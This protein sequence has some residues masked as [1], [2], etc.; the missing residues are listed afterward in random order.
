MEPTGW[1]EPSTKRGLEYLRQAPDGLAARPLLVVVED[2][3]SVVAR[4]LRNI[5]GVYVLGGA[6]LETVD[7]V[8]TRALLVERGVWS[9][10]P[11]TS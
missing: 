10:S 8:A 7:V 2:V 6:E 11:A 3:H 1:D 5:D 9:G 4:S